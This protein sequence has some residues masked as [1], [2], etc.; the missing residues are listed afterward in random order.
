MSNLTPVASFD[1][2]F[3]LETATIA[4]AGPGGIANAQ[5]QNLANRTEWLRAQVV[6]VASL[7]SDLLA[8]TAGKGT[9]AIGFRQNYTNAIS[10]LL[11]SK[12]SDIVCVTD[13]LSDNDIANLHAGVT[14]VDITTAANNCISAFPRQGSPTWQPI[15]VLFP[16]FGVCTTTAPITVRNKQFGKICLGACIIRSNFNGPIIEVGNPVGN[17]DDV[18]WFHMSGGFLE[19]QST[20]ANARALKV[21][22]AYGC[23]FTGMFLGGGSIALE[24]DGNA[25]KIDSVTC[26][27]SSGPGLKT[28][29]KAN[30]ESNLFINLQSELNNTYGVD[31]SVVSG[32]GG[33]SIFIGGYV[34]ANGIAG[35]YA[36][37]TMK[38]NIQN[39]YFN[40]QNG[41]DGIRLGGTVGANYQDPYVTVSG[42][43]VEAPTSGTPPKFINELSTSSIN[44]QYENNTVRNGTADMY[45]NASKS[46]NLRRRGD[47]VYIQNADAFTGATGTTTP[48]TGWTSGGGAPTFAVG[49]SVSQY[50]GQ[51]SLAV[52]GS[53]YA[54]QALTLPANALIRASCWAK[55]TA[56]D[57]TF[58]VFDNALN[59][60]LGSQVTASATPVRLEFYIPASVRGNATTFRPLA[61]NQAGT[62]VASFS[63]FV[64]EDMTN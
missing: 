15:N 17:V 9:Q 47:K 5:A 3:Q 23:S 35:F 54:H 13:F 28:G 50:G 49:T 24:L 14:P 60:A 52:S 31:L 10:Q 38:A 56:G 43:Q 21:D 7:R 33:S 22:H 34:E 6:G 18:L 19:Q 26:R 8:S 20:A 4:I 42:C 1:D 61:R 29:A 37:N 39:V 62:G 32:V 58:Q 46:I 40:I 57:A 27:G 64:F 48:P 41:M 63:N 51:A 2:V 44:C 45:G 36:A 30:N 16:Q 55:T 11:S 59:V 12:L 53:G 25:N